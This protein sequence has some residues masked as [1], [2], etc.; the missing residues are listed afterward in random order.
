MRYPHL[1][2]REIGGNVH[3]DGVIVRIGGTLGGEEPHVLIVL[4]VEDHVAVGRSPEP[5]LHDADVA[6]IDIDAQVI[7]SIAGEGDLGQ[8]G[9][10]VSG[11]HGL[12][13]VKV[14]D[15]VQGVPVQGVD[16][17]PFPAHED[18][19]A[20]AAGE[21]IVQGVARDAVVQVGA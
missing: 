16:V 20:Q 14:A 11:V 7:G 1:G 5:V 4:G 9:I 15:G 8:V 6:G 12:G 21:D 18:V 2:I 3:Q 17:R 10:D 13:Q 19:V